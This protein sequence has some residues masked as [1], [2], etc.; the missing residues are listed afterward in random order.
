M[1]DTILERKFRP[2]TIYQSQGTAFVSFLKIREKLFLCA[3]LP[4]A[5]SRIDR[6]IVDFFREHARLITLMSR[7]EQLRGKPFGDEFHK[8]MRKFLDAIRLLQQCRLS[9]RTLILQQL[10][11]EIGR[12]NEERENSNLMNA[13]K[14][15]SKS[16]VR[17]R[18]VNW[19]RYEFL[20][21]HKCSIFN[22][23]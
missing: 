1:P 9:E 23:P 13:L 19:C 16:V 15:V 17:A 7:M 3:R 8:V 5:P 2:Q 21:K 20:S 14:L 4:P 18:S 12:Y 11:G 6:L 10:R 22:L